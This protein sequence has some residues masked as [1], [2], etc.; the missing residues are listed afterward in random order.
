MSMS[1]VFW[2]V[3]FQLLSVLTGLI[4]IFNL[5]FMKDTFCFRIPCGFL[6]LPNVK[7]TYNLVEQ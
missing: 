4:F 2:A 6:K 5:M 1:G 3:A 7:L